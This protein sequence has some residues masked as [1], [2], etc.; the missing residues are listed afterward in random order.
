[1]E[2]LIGGTIIGALAG[3][4]LS[5]ILVPFGVHQAEWSFF[6]LHHLPTLRRPITRLGNRD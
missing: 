1:M 6:H 4:L 2:K 3:L 5:I